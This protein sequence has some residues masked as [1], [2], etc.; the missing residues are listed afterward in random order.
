M[1]KCIGQLAVRLTLA[2]PG[3]LRA[4]GR[5]AEL[6]DELQEDLPWRDEPEQ[7]ANAIREAVRG[8]RPEV[9]SKT[10]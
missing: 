9:Q 7:A 4:L 1:S 10:K 3:A 6:L 5:A 8:L 2:N